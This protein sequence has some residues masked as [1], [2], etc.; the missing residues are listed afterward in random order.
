MDQAV[1][2]MSPLPPSFQVDLLAGKR[3]DASNA[4]YMPYWSSMTDSGVRGRATLGTQAKGE[5]FLE[6]AVS[7]LVDLIREFKGL[8][9]GSRKDH[10]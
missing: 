3:P 6:A 4:V 8:E 7:G 10:H 9:I 2:E 1:D 5:A